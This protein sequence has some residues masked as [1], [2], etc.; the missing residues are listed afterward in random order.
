M[1]LLSYCSSDFHDFLF[2]LLIAFS[3]YGKKL[4]TV[5]RETRSEAM[6]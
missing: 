5:D 3:G 1:S 4:S 6:F 2:F